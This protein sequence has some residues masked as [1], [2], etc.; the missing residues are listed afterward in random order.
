LRLTGKF[1]CALLLLGG[2][3]ASAAPFT[4]GVHFEKLAVPQPSE[5]PPGRYEVL[6]VF[7]YGC[8]HCWNFEPYVEAWRQRKPADIELVLLPATFRPDFALFARGFYAAVVLGV[9]SSTHQAVWDAVWNRKA[10]TVSLEDIA[11]IYAS[12]GVDRGKFLEVARS[13][14]VDARLARATQMLEAYR[15]AGTPDVIVLGKYRVLTKALTSY[16]QIF[17]IAEYLVSLERAA[18]LKTMRRAARNK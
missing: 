9:M 13:V 18:K 6:E 2:G 11:N 4:E 17:E 10:R 1:L 12:L 3:A 5:A 16:P 14:D 8:V 15:V 7:S